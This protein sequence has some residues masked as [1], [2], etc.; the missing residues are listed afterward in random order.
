MESGGG[1]QKRVKG[2]QKGFDRME[3]VGGILN[4]RCQSG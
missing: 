1:G 3:R 4:L 2:A